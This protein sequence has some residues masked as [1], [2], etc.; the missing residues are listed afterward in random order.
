MLTM[1][2]GCMF[3][4][5][6]GARDWLTLAEKEY[7]DFLIVFLTNFLTPSVPFVGSPFLS[8]KRGKYSC[9]CCLIYAHV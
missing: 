4:A 3:L 7:S 9:F 2:I 5:I 1:I 6:I 8:I